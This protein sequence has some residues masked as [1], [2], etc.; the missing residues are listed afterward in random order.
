MFFQFMCLAIGLFFCLLLVGAFLIVGAIWKVFRSL[1]TLAT[2]EVIE[3]LESTYKKLEGLMEK[4]KGN[5]TNVVNNGGSKGSPEREEPFIPK[6]WQTEAARREAEGDKFVANMLSAEEKKQELLKLL[7][8]EIS[9]LIVKVK[10]ET[11]R[12]QVLDY[13]GNE[14]VRYSDEKL[15]GVIKRL[16]AI[17]RSENEQ[18]ALDKDAKSQAAS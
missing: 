18:A 7:H 5:V 15:T 6:I 13:V 9:D 16:E 17:I 2:K 12:K 1:K 11:V 3:A 10:S 4:E 8:A 14:S